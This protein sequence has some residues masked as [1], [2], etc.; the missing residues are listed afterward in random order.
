[1]TTS[2]QQPRRTSFLKIS[3]SL[4]STLA[5]FTLYPLV[6]AEPGEVVAVTCKVTYFARLGGDGI[7]LIPVETNQTDRI[8]AAQAE[9]F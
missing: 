5:L 9:S 1:M 8:P 6:A 2:G 4:V 3:R 7:Q